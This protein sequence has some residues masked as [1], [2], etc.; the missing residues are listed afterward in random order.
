MGTPETLLSQPVPGSFLGFILVIPPQ[1]LC[2]GV[3]PLGAGC[4]TSLGSSVGFAQGHAQ[5]ALDQTILLI[6]TLIP[7]A[8]FTCSVIIYLIKPCY[9]D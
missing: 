7:A 3:S 1:A 8:L 5:A 2:T 4:G 9:N 6:A